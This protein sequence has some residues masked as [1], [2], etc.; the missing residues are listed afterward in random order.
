MILRTLSALFSL[1]L[2]AG[3]LA[4]EPEFAIRNALRPGTHAAHCPAHGA[5][6]DGCIFHAQTDSVNRARLPVG[7]GTQWVA[8][9]PDAALVRI[10]PGGED[11]AADGSRYQLID[12]VA[13]RPEDADI[14]VT[15]DRLTVAP[16]PLQVVERRRVGIM[17]HSIKSWNE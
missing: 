17:K 10:G 14:V 5:T 9:T 12:I 3:T 6:P 4:A 7:P 16:A 13:W 15:F 2:A 11:T 8:R 1:G